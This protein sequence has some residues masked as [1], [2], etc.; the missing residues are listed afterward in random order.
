VEFKNKEECKKIWKYLKEN[1]IYTLPGWE[2]NEFSGLEDQFIRFT[3]GKEWEMD[4]VAEVL[5]KY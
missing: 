1:N 2:K 3:I 4:R 5:A